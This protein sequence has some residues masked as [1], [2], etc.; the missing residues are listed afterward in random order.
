MNYAGMLNNNSTLDGGDMVIGLLR[1]AAQSTD[2]SKSNP[3]GK[4]F[5]T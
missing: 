3:S 1:G 2:G 5:S 4:R